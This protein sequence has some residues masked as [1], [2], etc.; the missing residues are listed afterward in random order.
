MKMKL[1]SPE[2]GVITKNSDQKTIRKCYKSSLKNRRGTYA[3]TIQAGEPGWIAEV[4]A[5]NERRPGLA[6][7]VREREVKEKKF[8]LDTSLEKEL[9]DKITDVILEN[10]GAFTW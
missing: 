8:K 9:K 7:E 3:I 4:E 2:G 10:K 1:P 5:I 6:G